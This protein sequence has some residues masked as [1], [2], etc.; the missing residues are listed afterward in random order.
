[1]YGHWRM[2]AGLGL[3]LTIMVTIIFIV[4]KT[5]DVLSPTLAPEEEIE[6]TKR[7]TRVA[8]LMSPK[9]TFTLQEG[10]DGIVDIDLCAIAPCSNS[11]KSYSGFA[12]YVCLTPTVCNTF[13]ERFEGASYVS[14]TQTRG[15]RCESWSYVL[16]NSGPKDWGYRPKFKSARIVASLKHRMKVIR[17]N[18]ISPCARCRCNPVSIILR[19]VETGDAGLYILATHAG[20][21]SPQGLFRIVVTPK[22]VLTRPTT[23][24]IQYISKIICDD[25]C[26]SKVGEVEPLDIIQMATGFTDDNLWLKWVA[27]TAHEQ[28]V[29]DCLACATARPHLITDP[30]PLFPSDIWGYNCMLKLTQMA[31][32]SNCT[33]L[34]SLFPPID[35]GTKTGPFTPSKGRGGYTCFKLTSASPKFNLGN[36]SSDWCNSTLA[37]NMVGHWARGG[38]Y[39]YCGGRRLFTRIPEASIGLCAMTRLH[40]PLTLLGDRLIPLNAKHVSNGQLANRRRRHVLNKRGAEVNFDLS[41]NSPTYI[42]SIGVPRGVPNEYKLTDQIA[43]GFESFPIISAIFPIT[44]NKNV[45]RINFVHYNVLRLANL[46]RDAV[47]GL[48]EQ[49]G[50]TSLMAIQ[51]RMALDMLLAEKGGVCAMFGD[52][53][54]T[55]IPN[56]TAPDGSVT[57]ALE[58]LRTLSKTMHEQS[59]INNPMEEWMTNMFGK[60]K[61]LIMSLL[62]SVATFMGIL[63]TCGCCCVP[64]IRSLCVRLISSTIEEKAAPS[65]SYQMPLLA[66]ASEGEAYDVSADKDEFF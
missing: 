30:A 31:S 39:Y 12:K 64:C 21:K 16:V 61:N 57:K 65:A 45:D 49:L 38:L 56:N 23:A 28:M 37:G 40:A 48:A 59:G 25:K 14:I 7:G 66:Y 4:C 50:P 41:S 47:E 44:P 51:N 34:A 42:D 11:D 1:M 10:S 26:T 62:I 35:N 53:C 18:P 2:V 15:C 36:V 19:G 33:T 54:C 52:M 27:G 63:V 22:P 60:W 8:S 17:R 32:P 3:L 5:N 20:N 43:A 24:V 58:G 13:T 55:F 9:R 6:R 46:T 29:G